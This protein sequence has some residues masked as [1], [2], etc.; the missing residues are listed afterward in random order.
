MEYMPFVPASCATDTN[1]QDTNA[2]P[3]L[4]WLAIPG[5]ILCVVVIAVVVYFAI[6]GSR[7]Q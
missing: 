1:C 2:F 5:V 7:G 4:G 3:D 6:R